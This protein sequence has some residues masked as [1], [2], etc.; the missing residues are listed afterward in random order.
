MLIIHNVYNN[1]QMFNQTVIACPTLLI[2][3]ASVWPARLGI[4]CCVLM[5]MLRVVISV[6]K[7]TCWLLVEESIYV[8]N[9]EL[10][11]VRLVIRIISMSVW[12]VL[13]VLLLMLILKNV[14]YLKPVLLLNFIMEFSVYVHLV[15]MYQDNKIVLD[16]LV[17]VLLVLV[18]VSVHSA[19]VGI[20]WVLVVYVRLVQLIAWYVLLLAY[21]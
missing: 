4:V 8:R 6:R 10:I 19:R 2:L 1:A 15:S 12:N 11:I 5:I 16:V 20:F 13:R 14:K 17:I 3:G 21:V 7:D 18:V 9:V